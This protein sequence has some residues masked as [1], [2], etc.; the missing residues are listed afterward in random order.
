[1]PNQHTADGA[2]GVEVVQQALADSGI[3]ISELARRM[4]WVHTRPN[5]TKTNRALGRS[6]ASGSHEGAIKSV[7]YERAIALIE[8]MG[9]EPVDYGL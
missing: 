4:G 3:T 2:I 9:L 7:S 5:L 6:K 1:M 8:A